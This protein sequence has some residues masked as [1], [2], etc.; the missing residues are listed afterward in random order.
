LQPYTNYLPHDV[1][2][3]ALTDYPLPISLETA[4]KYL[5]IDPGNT[6]E[7]QLI[8]NLIAAATEFAE[9][10]TKRDFIIKTYLT[11]RDSFNDGFF[12]LRKS[13]FQELVSFQYFTDNTLTPV[14]SVYYTT[15]QNDFASIFLLSAKSWPSNI[16]PRLQ[17]IQ[18]VFKA[19]YAIDESGI[20]QALKEGMLSHIS[21]MYE[22]RGDASFTTGS[23]DFKI[24]H[25]PSTSVLIYDMYRIKDLNTI[26]Y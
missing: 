18:I 22:N 14:P 23:E 16:D 20:P 10:Y 6:T 2:F 17:A 4:R 26:P 15:Q 24:A 7:D 19:G 3:L 9:L 5:K 21:N 8:V 13:Q 11:F 25:L 1:P 12:T